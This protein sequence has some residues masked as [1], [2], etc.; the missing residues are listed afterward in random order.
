MPDHDIE[1][2]LVINCD[3]YQ[4]HTHSYIAGSL[5]LIHLPLICLYIYYIILS[6]DAVVK[7]QVHQRNKMSSNH[8]GF[9]LCEDVSVGEVTE[10]ILQ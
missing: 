3:A 1:H 4:V 5:S 10:S 7:L 6:C 2:I 9:L 8:F